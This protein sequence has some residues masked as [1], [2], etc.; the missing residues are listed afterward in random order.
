MGCI[1]SATPRTLEGNPEN[2]DFMKRRKEAGPDTGLLKNNI[3]KT[4]ITIQPKQINPQKTLRTFDCF[5]W[6]ASSFGVICALLNPCLDKG[7]ANASSSVVW[8]C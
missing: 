2:H 1:Q 5:P 7:P 3:K 8:V 6:V 4:P